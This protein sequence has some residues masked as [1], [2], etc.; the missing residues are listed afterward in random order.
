MAT[1]GKNRMPDIILRN[2]IYNESEVTS[3]THPDQYMSAWTKNISL[4][5]DQN[6][7]NT[8]KSESAECACPLMSVEPIGRF[9]SVATDALNSQSLT[10][11]TGKA[12]L[13]YL[14]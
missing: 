1:D 8:S 5:R 9:L 12:P 10:G 14:A 7:K 11:H 2:M 3:A 13:T 6:H 4:P